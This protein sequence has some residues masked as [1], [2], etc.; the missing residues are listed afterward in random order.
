MV[1]NVSNSFN[2]YL[3]NSDYIMKS[4][5]GIEYG[6]IRPTEDGSTYVGAPKALTR[7]GVEDGDYVKFTFN[8]TNKVVVL[9]PV[10]ASIIWELE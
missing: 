7:L 6:G 1:L 5:S 4:V 2:D 9:E 8:I 3:G 10:P